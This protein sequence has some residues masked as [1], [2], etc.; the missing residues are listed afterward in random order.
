MYCL[1]LLSAYHYHLTKYEVPLN[2]S[3][4]KCSLSDFYYRELILVCQTPIWQNAFIFEGLAALIRGDGAA[5]SQFTTIVNGVETI[6]NLQKYMKPLTIF[7]DMK[8]RIADFFKAILCMILNL[9]LAMLVLVIYGFMYAFYLDHL[10]N[11]A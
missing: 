10:L 7:Y 1:F 4:R 11:A 2:L 5:E 3:S 8:L 6:I 9:K